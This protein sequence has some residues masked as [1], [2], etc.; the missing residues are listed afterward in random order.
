M[1]R[2]TFQFGS[3]FDANYRVDPLFQRAMDALMA[4]TPA[5]IPVPVRKSQTRFET[6]LAEIRS[7]LSS[8]EPSARKEH[9]E[10][11]VRLESFSRTK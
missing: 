4:R 9:S 10:R 1:H 3:E 11:S 7:P 5:L 6:R 8:A 2:M